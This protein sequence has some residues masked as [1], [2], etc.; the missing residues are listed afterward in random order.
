M[1]NIFVFLRLESGIFCKNVVVQFF[2][3]FIIF[4]KNSKLKSSTLCVCEGKKW[5]ILFGVK[6][7][8][9]VLAEIIS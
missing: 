7:N 3:Y 8:S 6:A 4:I 1:K 9:R 2:V 5:E